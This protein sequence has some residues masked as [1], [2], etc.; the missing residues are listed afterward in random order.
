MERA[1]STSKK[2]RIKIVR[3][4]ML[5]NESAE[6]FAARH[7]MSRMTLHQWVRRLKNEIDCVPLQTNQPDSSMSDKKNN[8]P[9]LG[10]LPLEE[11]LKE[12]KKR[13]REAELK[14]LA[15]NTMIDIAEEQGMQIRKK[16]GVKQCN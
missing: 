8:Y 2:M 14:N 5:G 10:K 4:F 6:D 7:Q 3:E 11:Q 1:K 15:L 9:E 13:L 16:S 12:L